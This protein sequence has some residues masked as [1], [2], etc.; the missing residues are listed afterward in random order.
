MSVLAWVSAW[1][2]LTSN[3]LLDWVNLCTSMEDVHL[4]T[5]ERQQPVLSKARNS[6]K[7]KEERRD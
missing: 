6:N 4:S 2:T 1:H 3:T 7:K 5:S